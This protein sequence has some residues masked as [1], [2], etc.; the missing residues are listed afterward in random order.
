MDSLSPPPVPS[1]FFSADEADTEKIAASIASHW[2]S[3]IALVLDGPLGA[4]KTRFVSGLAAA[5]GSPHLVASPTFPLV[6]EYTGGR[7]PIFHFDFYRLSSEDE[8][9]AL[10][11]EDYLLDGI[12]A[13]EWGLKFPAVFPPGSLLVSISPTSPSDR[14]ISLSLLSDTP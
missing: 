7:L 13:V 3:P 14:S 1:L 5:L 6:H 2:S 9:W 11:F 4:G 10:G 12:V 8:V